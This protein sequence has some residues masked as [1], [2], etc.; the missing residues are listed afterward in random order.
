MRSLRKTSARIKLLSF[1]E[2]ATDAVE[3]LSL[4]FVDGVQVLNDCAIELTASAILVVGKIAT[5]L[6]Q[7]ALKRAIGRSHHVDAGKR[8]Q[9]E[10]VPKVDDRADDCRI[11]HLRPLPRDRSVC[12]IEPPSRIGFPEVD[13]PSKPVVVVLAAAKSASSEQPLRNGRVAA[14]I[15]K[16]KTRREAWRLLSRRVRP[17]E[18]A[19]GRQDTLGFQRFEGGRFRSGRF[20]G[21]AASGFPKGVFDPLDRGNG[22]SLFCP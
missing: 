3:I 10:T 14:M 7:G 12:V 20:F 19:R 18:V 22:A 8:C 1:R 2:D 5:G 6:L 17:G 21:V 11:R 13:S 16:D 4:A 15:S 9:I